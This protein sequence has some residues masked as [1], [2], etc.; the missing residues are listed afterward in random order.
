MLKLF[1]NYLIKQSSLKKVILGIIIILIFNIILFPFFP[2][3]FHVASFPTSWILD[4]RFSYTSDILYTIFDNLGIEGRKVYQLS[5]IFVDFPY[6]VFYGFVY[7]FMIVLLLKKTNLTTNSY[8]ILIPFGISFFDILEN[9]GLVSLLYSYPKKL[10][11]L[12][13]ITSLT[14]SC[15]WIFAILTVI[16]AIYLISKQKKGKNKPK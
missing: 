7:S 12:V 16:I 15:K 6:A 8:L 4:L 3:L 9:I 13:N 5:E 1:V 11:Y 2:K 14:T 10:T